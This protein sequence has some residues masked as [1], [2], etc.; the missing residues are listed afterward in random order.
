VVLFEVFGIGGRHKL[1][2]AEIPHALV[3]LKEEIPLLYEVVESSQVGGAL[4]K[5]VLTR[6]SLKAAEAR[7]ANP[8]PPLSNLK[9]HLIDR[10]GTQVTGSLYA[11]VLGPVPGTSTGLAMRFTSIPPEIQV[12]LNRLAAGEPGYDQPVS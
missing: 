2:L 6:I 5:G 9:I 12:V 7:L 8:V 4:A 11:K 3:E 1:S 10:D